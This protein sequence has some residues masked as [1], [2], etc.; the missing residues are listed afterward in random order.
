MSSPSRVRGGAPAAI[1]FSAC[2]RPQN[3]SGRKK[4]TILLSAFSKIKFKH[5]QWPSAVQTQIQ[6]LSRT[7]SVFKDIPGLENLEKLFQHF[8]GP[9]SALL[10]TQQ[11]REA[12]YSW[13]Q[14]NP[15]QSYG[16]S[17]AIRAHSVTC[18][19]T[20]VNA[21]TCPALTPPGRP[22]V[23]LPT[24]AGWEAEL[25]WVVGYIPRWFTCL[26]TVTQPSWSVDS[27]PT[28]RWTHNLLIVST[29]SY[30]DATKPQPMLLLP[31]RVAWDDRKGS[32]P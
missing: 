15:S 22:I 20:Q 24:P 4:N 23:G 1:A 2:F 19:P 8:Q 21:T 26:Q 12:V 10:L 16:A 7:T 32:V 31:E 6:G 30:H 27:D 14:D 25:T 3:A 28:G 18:N 9:A 5:I 17:H 29:S 11:L 13:S